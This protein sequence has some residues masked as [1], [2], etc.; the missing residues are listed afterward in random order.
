MLPCDCVQPLAVVDLSLRMHSG[1][2]I[3]VRLSYS[4]AH[5]QKKL[6]PLAVLSP[7][8]TSHTEFCRIFLVS[9][10]KAAVSR[11]ITIVEPSGSS[12]GHT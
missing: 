3:S 4:S 2:P 10:I 9:A 12:S 7:R 1:R 6:H 11:M 5:W 8:R